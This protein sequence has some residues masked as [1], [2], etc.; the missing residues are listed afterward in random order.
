MVYTGDNVFIT[1]FGE[2]DVSG[3]RHLENNL[4]NLEHMFKWK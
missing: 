3:E 1:L 4:D 2:N